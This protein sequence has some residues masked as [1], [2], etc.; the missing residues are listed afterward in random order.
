[1]RPSGRVWRTLAWAAP[2]LVPIALALL[3]FLF[4]W[5][6]ALHL[7]WVAYPPGADFS[8]LVLSH[9][10][11]AFYW[12]EALSRYG[13]WPL[14]NE[15]IYGGLPFAADPLAGIWYP[16]ALALLVLPLPLGFNLLLALHMAWGGYGL[17]CFLRAEGLAL[18]ASLLG[19]VAF[20][21]APKLVA[22]L[23]AGHVSL[24]FA[25]AWT[26]WLLLGPR[27]TASCRSLSSSRPGWARSSRSSTS[28]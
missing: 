10:P 16:P 7:S 3:A 19:A 21:G 8:D 9:L 6:L 25:V 17:F 5:P 22:H 23:G 15:Q 18:P 14:W 20:T 11:N 12:R 1:M 24:V 27:T 13:Q 26:P 2:W 28:P 4:I